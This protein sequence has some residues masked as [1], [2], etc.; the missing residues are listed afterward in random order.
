MALGYFVCQLRKP[1]IR[2]KK[3]N[4]FHPLCCD[5]FSQRSREYL[6]LLIRSGNASYHAR[7]RRIK[8]TVLLFF[9]WETSVSENIGQVKK[10]TLPVCAGFREPPPPPPSGPEDP[11]QVLLLPLRRRRCPGGP[12]APPSAAA[13]ASGGREGRRRPPWASRTTRRRCWCSRASTS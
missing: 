8:H 10:F 5:F 3:R 2:R 9:F 13:A 4:F 6:N 7:P 1:L 12:G 11:G